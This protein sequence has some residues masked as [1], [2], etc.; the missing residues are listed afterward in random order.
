[1]L[2]L[3]KMMPSVWPNETT[4]ESGQSWPVRARNLRQLRGQALIGQHLSYITSAC[5]LHGDRLS[6]FRE[7]NLMIL[8][9]LIQIV[10]ILL[11]Q[12]SPKPWNHWL[13]H[14]EGQC[15]DSVC[16]QLPATTS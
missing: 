16:S 3:M 9:H 7:T 5:E 2:I 8:I 12:N 10:N 11:H 15:H 4:A 13:T 6:I 1:M 14:T